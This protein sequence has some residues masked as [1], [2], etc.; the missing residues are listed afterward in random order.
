MKLE[1]ILQ[2]FEEKHN[3]VNI[4]CSS[5]HIDDIIDILDDKPITKDT[6]VLYCNDVWR[7][8]NYE[9]KIFNHRSL[10]K[11]RVII[12]TAGYENKKYNNQHYHVS[13]PMA[14]WT[15]SACTNSFAPL[16]NNLD[17][18]FGCLNNRTSIDRFIL[19]YNLYA[20]NLLDKILFTQNLC[21]SD[22]EHLEEDLSQFD[23]KKYYEYK[24]LLP[25]RLD[26]HKE[27]GEINF[28]W[29]HNKEGWQIPFEHPAFANAYCFISVEAAIEEYP[30]TENI[31]LPFCSEKSFKAFIT[32][33]IPLNVGAR[34]HNAFLKSL[35]YETM[36]DFL[37][38]G[39]DDM[40]Y[41]QK[42]DAIVQTIAKGKEY[43]KDFY[44]SHTKELEHNYNLV[45]STKVEELVE[46][47]I[48]ELLTDI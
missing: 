3:A 7:Y 32:R 26:E 31:N 4:N 21:E 37:P 8:S 27:L 36:E 12:L 43:V 48:D 40:P 6:V 46:K 1:Y 35:G 14:Y 16:A 18:G 45:H 38:T 2:C 25:I 34:G 39:F 23:V 19:G 10:N 41:L 20:N 28:K 22:F 30:Y 15:R 9:Q 11:K 33:Q 17:Y 5:I 42:V 44:F 13:F 24:N 29:F 47:R